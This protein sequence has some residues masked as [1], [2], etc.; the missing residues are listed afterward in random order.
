MKR[1]FAASLLVLFAGRSL[2]GDPIPGL[3]SEIKTERLKATVEKLASFGTRCVVSQY[4]D[5]A[6]GIGA[7]AKWLRA[8]LEKIPNLKVD[9]QAV[10]IPVQ[11]VGTLKG[12]NLIATLPGASDETV[13]I[14]AHYDSV[15]AQ[16]LDGKSD[17]PGANDDG[18]G[19]A[20][21][22][23]AARVMSKLKPRATIKFILFTSEEMGLKG[24]QLYAAQ[25]KS[26][27]EKIL[28]VLN[29]DIV[30]NSKGENGLSEPFKIR[31][32]SEGLAETE[33]QADLTRRKVYGGGEESP[34]RQLARALV[35]VA[36]KYKPDFTPMLV[37]RRDRIGRA[38]DHRSFNE[39]G[40]PAIRL[41]EPIEDFRHQH[42]DVAVVQG[43]QWGDLPEFLDYQ[44]LTRVAK[45]NVAALAQLALAPPPPAT[46]KQVFNRM[47]P[48]TR[49]VWKN[50]PGVKYIVRWRETSSPVWQGEK[51]VGEERQ[52][53]TKEFSKDT[54][55]FG[56]Q[57][58]GADGHRSV[59]VPAE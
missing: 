47:S 7:S 57:S 48:E 59:V 19:C 23:E 36:R 39:A 30:G 37:Y 17:A 46:V 54:Y 1:S 55:I 16:G 51:A 21:V 20:V 34:S 24:S 52:Y 28:A 45:L 38:G 25:A 14:C 22:L 10:D 50:E 5:P 12:W 49:I 18:S 13:I 31:V 4:E 3:I 8:E 53:V 32:F 43:V 6:R 40:F 9:G 42:R 2:G 11:G 41:T 58:V 27:G 26:K 35:E 56:V 15:P 29:N 44:Y 33:N